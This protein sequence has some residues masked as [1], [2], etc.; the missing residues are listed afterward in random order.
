MRTTIQRIF[1]VALALSV[2]V[3]LQACYP[4]DSV[5]TLERDLVITKYDNTVDFGQFGTFAVDDSVHYLADSTDDIHDERPFEDF[6]L[7]T[8]RNNMKALGYVEESDP[9]NNIPDL[10]LIA[11]V[12]TST[13][14]GYYGA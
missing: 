13:W 3:L 8:V 5:S 9:E 11:S 10:A 7:N 4:G 2:I 6:I 14:R 12:T 1:P